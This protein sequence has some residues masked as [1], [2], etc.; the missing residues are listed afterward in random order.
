MLR[1]LRISLM[2]LVALAVP[3]QGYA[4][5][6][7]FGCGPAHHGM[8]GTQ[9]QLQLQSQSQSQ[10]AAAHDDDAAVPQHSHEAHAETAVG[11]HH[12]DA[13]EPSHVHE[14]KHGTPGKVGKGSCTP[15]ASCCVVA[16]LPAAMLVF[17]PVALV[18]FFVPLAPRNVAPFLT[19]GPERPPRFLLV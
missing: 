15:C 11:H 18:D 17:E 4:A 13:T 5:V 9:L 3:A 14:L 1:V 7:M 8:T 16:A 19:E 2:W 6:T 10:A 12:D